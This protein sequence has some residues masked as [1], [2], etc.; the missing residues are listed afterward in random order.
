MAPGVSGVGGIVQGNF[1]TYQPSVVDG[2]YVVDTRD[3]PSLL[4]MGMGY[5]K[6]INEAYTLP[7]APAA[8]TVG[9]IVAS[10]ALSNGTL[11]VTANPDCPR[12]VDVEV[13]TGTTAIT[14]GTVAVTYVGNDGASATETLSAVC[15]LST[16]VTQTLSRGVTSI[17]AINV[18]G[19][20]GGTSPWIRLSTKAQ[21]SLPVAQNATGFSVSREYD[22]GATVAVGTLGTSM[23]SIIPTTAPNGTRTYSFVYAFVSPVT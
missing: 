15:A 8:A 23:G 13:G 21:V 22:A 3:A 19:V 20:V 17:S 1:G 2:S 12:P 14:A 10:G 6:Q 4:A 5:V 7:L 18:A 16:S 11:A 9:A